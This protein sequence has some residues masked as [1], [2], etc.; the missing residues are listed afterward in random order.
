MPST[1][2]SIILE[3]T[4]HPYVCAMPAQAPCYK[5]SWNGGTCVPCNIG[6]QGCPK[7]HSVIDRQRQTSVGLL[8]LSHTGRRKHS[9]KLNK[10]PRDLQP[11]APLEL[12]ARI[13]FVIRHLQ[14]AQSFLAS[15]NLVYAAGIQHFKN[16]GGRVVGFGCDQRSD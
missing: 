14:C 15:H 11:V 3:L 7:H 2:P 13:P 5:S 9:V 8:V 16:L 12:V 6:T 4:I 1:E 10:T